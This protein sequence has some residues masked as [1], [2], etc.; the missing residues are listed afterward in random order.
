MILEGSVQITYL[1]VE[2]SRLDEVKGK[3]ERGQEIGD[4]RA[5]W[6]LNFKGGQ[7]IRPRMIFA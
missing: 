7:A 5:G 2:G 4:D 1:V 3:V 6:Q